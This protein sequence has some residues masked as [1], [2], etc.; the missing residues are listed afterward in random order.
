MTAT[1]QG[2]GS[3]NGVD[4]D[5]SN[6][7]DTAPIVPPTHSPLELVCGQVHGAI[8]RFLASDVSS[9][10]LRRVQVKTE[11]AIGVILK[12]LESYE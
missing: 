9:Q 4:H 5:V 7:L 10:Q 6:N 3:A 1:E 2:P 12:T 8:S 11:E